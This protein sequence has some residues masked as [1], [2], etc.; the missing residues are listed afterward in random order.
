MRKINLRPIALTC[1]LLLQ[2]S[3]PGPAEPQ[4]DTGHAE[5]KS[6]P[7][8]GYPNK[9]TIEK[10]TIAVEQI[11]TDDQAREPFGKLNPYRYGIL[12]VLVVIQND[13]PDTIR[14]DRMTIDYLLPDRSKIE[15]T[16]ASELRFLKS[17]GQPKA[18][19][20][21]LGGMKLGKTKT[22]PLADWTIEGRA[23]AAKMIPAGQSA[24]GFFYFQSPSSAAGKIYLSGMVHAG[25]GQELFYFEIP[26]K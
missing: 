4:K 12:P 14:V 19:P 3:I 1:L 7:A 13:G 15:N 23:F 20:G 2:M 26:V 16:P 22:N 11:E 18:I 6:R 8:T 9:Q 21:P 10:V 5:F 17:P 24:S 25:S